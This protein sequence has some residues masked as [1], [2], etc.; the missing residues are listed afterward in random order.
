[1]SVND[2]NIVID[3]A[4]VDAVAQKAAESVKSSIEM[5]SVDAIATLVAEKMAE[6]TEKTIK[7]NVEEDTTKTKKVSSNFADLSKEQRF[8]KGLVAFKNGDAAGIAE[9]NSY[10]NKAWGESSIEKSNYQNVTVAADGGALV[11]DP[12]FIAEIERL[13]DEYGVAARLANVR[14]TDRDS[15]TLLSGTN[16]VSFTRTG[17]ATAQNAQKLTYAATTASLDKYILTLVMTSE[18][19]EDAAINLWQDA[20]TEIAR[21]RAKLF[22]QLVFTD[23][24]D[25]LLYAPDSGEA[26]KTLTVGSAI[27]D[28][29]ADDA[30][31]ARYKVVG[32]VR[33][34][35]RYFMHP[36]V[37]AM[38][39][40]SR[41]GSGATSGSY[42]FGGVGQAVTPNIDGVP[43]E[44]VDVLPAKGD[45]TANEPFAVFGDLSRVMIH[46]KR[47]LETKIFDSGVVKDAG[48]SDLNLITQ[49]SWALRATTRVKVQTRF[50][51]AFV[52]LGT[53]TVS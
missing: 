7:K 18:L 23:A 30:M 2:E 46:V 50:P 27:T 4:V 47:V 43:V 35:G 26:F 49:D 45:I 41:E 11:P 44:L 42:L 32:S 16:E 38:L 15:V 25:G 20:S 31:D 40:Q 22:D 13:T 29:T 3:E 10:V 34:K 53:G 1:M 17:E 36:S 51:D 39:R 21:A 52:I 5:P 6:A 14:L 19:I 8:A 9:Y 24:T 12:E 37:W 33:T 28:F 48:G